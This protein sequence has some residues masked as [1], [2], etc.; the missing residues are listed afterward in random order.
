ML[1]L[2]PFGTGLG[3]VQSTGQD[4]SAAQAGAQV[5]PMAEQ[6]EKKCYS[7]H[8]L[9]SGDK[10]GPDLK[11]VTQRRAMDWLIQFVQ[12]PSS[13]RRK[14][15][16]TTLEL[17]A[18][19][20][21]EVMPDQDMSATEIISLMN[22]IAELSKQGKTFVPQAGKLVREPLPQ[23]V[24]L[25]RMLFT[26]ETR[27]QAGGAACIACHTVNGV[28]VLGGGTLGPELTKAVVKFSDAELVNILQNPSFPNMALT[29][30]NHT[31][32][33]DE[34]VQLVALLRAAQVSELTPAAT[35]FRAVALATVG[36]I[37]FLVVMNLIWSKRLRGVRKTLVGR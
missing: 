29:F 9:G 4:T 3:Q 35:K 36:L 28:G 37:L 13:M 22:W 14:G 19:Y 10:K 25:G 26:G 20:A 31:F 32:T 34:L 18:K 30:R 21:P 5:D 15:D 24:P 23:D 7:C 17:F 8:N 6:F 27:F 16:P 1:L 33:D 2:A 11:D 12:S